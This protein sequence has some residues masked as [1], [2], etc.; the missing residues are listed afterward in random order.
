MSWTAARDGR[1][2]KWTFFDMNK[3]PHLDRSGP[4]EIVHGFKTLE[5]AQSWAKE[6]E[7]QLLRRGNARPFRREGESNE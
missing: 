1:T 7:Q 3:A 2:R 4:G 6:R 5:E